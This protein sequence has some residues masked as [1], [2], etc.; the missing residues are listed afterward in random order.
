MRDTRLEA[1][2]RVAAGL[3]DIDRRV[4]CPLTYAQAQ[5]DHGFGY[6]DDRGGTLTT[7]LL[8]VRVEELGV[9]FQCDLIKVVRQHFDLAN[10]SYAESGDAN[11]FATRYRE[12]QERRISSKPRRVHFSRE[13]HESLGKLMRESDVSQQRK[14]REA[15]T[16]AFKIW[17][18]FENGED[19]MPYLSKKVNNADH[20]DGLLWHYGMHHFHLSSRFG[21]SEFV[22]RSDYLLFAMVANE[23]VFFVDVRK[24]RD[25][26]NL[27]WVRQNLLA[28]VQANWPEIIKSR[29]LTGTRGASLTDEEIKVLRDKNTNVALGLG[30]STLAPLGFGTMADGSSA[31]CRFWAMRLLDEIRAIET[32]FNS[33]PADL[34]SAL[35]SKGIVMSG[36]SGLSLGLLVNV[37]PSS[38]HVEHLQ[39]ANHLCRVLCAMGFTIVDNATGFPVMI[40]SETDI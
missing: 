19:L 5:L 1:V 4:F 2:S 30:E 11:Y 21:S 34:H 24:H 7:S 25:P 18:L 22:E 6:R 31:F 29:S 36:G 12:M 40:R 28:I 35:E 38:E 10:I 23:D 39:N 9:K 8:T 26:Q 16:T 3:T 14:A 20:S 37:A 27:L 13:T 33:P 32:Y 15:W 17:H